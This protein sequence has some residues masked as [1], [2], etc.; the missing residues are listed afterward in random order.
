[1]TSKASANNV[2]KYVKIAREQALIG[3]Y[4]NSINFYSISLDLIKQRI[5][6]LTTKDLKEIW[7]KFQKEI[8]KEMKIMQDMLKL[9]NGLTNAK[10]DFSNDYSDDIS[11]R[12]LEQ[13]PLENF[14]FQ[15]P[16]KRK[17]NQSIKNSYTYG[18]NKKKP[19]KKQYT[20]F[21]PNQINEWKN[22]DFNLI[23]WRKNQNNPQ[24][25][26]DINSKD[27]DTTLN[28][29]E[30]FDLSKS[31]I[32][33][34]SLN[35]SAVS[36]VNKS[37]LRQINRFTREHNRK[38]KTQIPETII[39]DDWE[40]RPIHPTNTDIYMRADGTIPFP[41]PYKSNNYNNNNEGYHYQ[42]SYNPMA[43]INDVLASYGDPM[44]ELQSEETEPFYYRNPEYDNIQSRYMNYD[45]GKKP[46]NYHED[47]VSKK[48]AQKNRSKSLINTSNRG[49]KNKNNNNDNQVKRSPFLMARYPNS[50]GDGP[51]TQLIEMLEQEVVETNPNVSFDDIADLE[52]AKKT[53]QETVFLPLIIPDFFKGIRRAWKGVLLYGPPGT[54]KTLLAK[55]LATQG[56][57]T[58][59]N[60]HSS[61]FASKWRGESEK[62]VRI[63]FE[64]AKFY[65]PTTIFI[66]EV[67]ALC[68]KRGE[69]NEGEASRRVK[70]EMLVQMDGIGSESKEDEKGNKDKDKPK[71]ITV[72]GAT[73]RP[74]DLDDAIRRRFEKRIYIPLPTEKG[75]EQLFNIY[76]KGIKLNED[77]DIKKLVKLSEGYSG[78][79]ISNVCREAALMPMRKNLDL[80]SKNFNLEEIVKEEKFQEGLNAGISMNDL[81]QALKNISKSVGNQDLKVYEKW[82]EEYKSV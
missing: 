9:S 38:N 35:T 39:E 50:N 59:F 74:W 36:T 26:S 42:R 47:K 64:M 8:I 15:N 79:D 16:D 14:I 30:Q 32:G 41:K 37:F 78:A 65:A 28:P 76:L 10:F 75:R 70:A 20:N 80:V 68:S 71:L 3:F 19:Q 12:R 82:T 73:N 29:L 25:P 34:T 13:Q 11:K 18:G 44:G 55:A 57:T 33:D 7:L 56:K 53:L 5:K 17:I 4:Q 63:V 66:D 77:I 60:L 6:D 45:K 24:T 52:N 48:L 46:K 61:S 2:K 81:V 72:I 67:D 21:H 31:N 54:G 51:D 27:T 1:M 23:E 58:F 43:L 49:N 69:G 40:E 22:D 62:L